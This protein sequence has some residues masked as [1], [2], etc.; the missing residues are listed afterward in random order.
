MT[1]LRRWFGDETSEEE[2]EITDNEEKW[3]DIERVKLIR[4]KRGEDKRERR[5]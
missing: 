3:S 2:S 5:G 1:A 4:R